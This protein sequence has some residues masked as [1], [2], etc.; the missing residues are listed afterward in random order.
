[1]KNLTNTDFVNNKERLQNLS[2]TDG[3]LRLNFYFEKTKRI[4]RLKKLVKQNIINTQSKQW[5]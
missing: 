2:Y 5:N 4:A 3:E 1:M